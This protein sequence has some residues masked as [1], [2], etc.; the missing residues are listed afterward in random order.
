MLG[1]QMFVEG[2]A[3][4]L[5]SHAFPWWGEYGLSSQI[6]LSAAEA[7][8]ASS[9]QKTEG[10]SWKIISVLLDSKEQRSLV[11][12]Q[13]NCICTTKPEDWASTVNVMHSAFLVC[14]LICFYSM[15]RGT[16]DALGRRV[17]EEEWT[18]FPTLTG[19]SRN[20]FIHSSVSSLVM[21]LI[22]LQTYRFPP[23]PFSWLQEAAFPSKLCSSC[24]SH[25]GCRSC[26][27]L[28][29]QPHFLPPYIACAGARSSTASVKPRHSYIVS[30]T[31]PV[32]QPAVH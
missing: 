32:P 12:L 28:Q 19:V 15:Q 4:L 3:L 16:W 13:R 2:T 24:S 23:F 10:Y 8:E 26:S 11:I 17:H 6:H 22:L 18:M 21:V 9:K 30:I 14:L 7:E 31:G 29:T 1:Q 5:C 25:H 27:V 20:Q